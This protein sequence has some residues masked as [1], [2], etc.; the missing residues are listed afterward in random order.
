MKLYCTNFEDCGF[1]KTYQDD[2]PYPENTCP[3][4]FSMALVYS[5]NYIPVFIDNTLERENYI[6]AVLWFHL[7]KKK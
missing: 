3:D 5:D 4:C 7:M 1:Q 6:N 2:E